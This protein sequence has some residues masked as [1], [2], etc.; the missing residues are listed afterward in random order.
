ML[1][2]QLAVMVRADGYGLAPGRNLKSELARQGRRPRVRADNG[3]I[4]VA[5]ATDFS[6]AAQLFAMRHHTN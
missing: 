6:A 4:A 2:S 1:P 5:A 3:S